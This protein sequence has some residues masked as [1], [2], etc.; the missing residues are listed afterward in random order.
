MTS[1]TLGEAAHVECQNQKEWSAKEL[2]RC[3]P[4][5]SPQPLGSDSQ[6]QPFEGGGELTNHNRSFSP[7]SNTCAEGQG[8]ALRENILGENH[9]KSDFQG[10]KKPFILPLGAESQKGTP[11][12]ENGSVSGRWAVVCDES[13]SSALQSFLHEQGE[14]ADSWDPSRRSGGREGQCAGVCQGLAAGYV[15]SLFPKLTSSSRVSNRFRF[16]KQHIRSGWRRFF[17]AVAL[18]PTAGPTLAEPPSSLAARAWWCPGFAASPRCSRSHS[19]LGKGCGDCWSPGRPF[20]PL[21]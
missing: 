12:P 15:P 16:L 4:H 20:L 10:G 19:P 9:Y 13:P 11:A 7:L 8:P 6:L 1:S 2:K 5:R 17:S 21:C 14:A 18:S 3:P